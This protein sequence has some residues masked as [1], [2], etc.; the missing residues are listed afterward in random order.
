M[1]ADRIRKILTRRPYWGPQSIARE[2][3]ATPHVVR[4][5]ASRHKI[6]FM[7]RYE[8]ENEMD[9]LVEAIEKLEGPAYAEPRDAQRE[10]DGVA[11]D[12]G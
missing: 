12:A 10:R 8:L 3:G 1:L 6:K 5:T 7:D 9:K 4:V 11:D 2:V